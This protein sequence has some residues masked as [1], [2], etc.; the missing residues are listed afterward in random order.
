MT[1][2]S[3]TP[4]PQ[5]APRKAWIRRHP[6]WTTIIV[7]FAIGAIGSTLGGGG[8]GNPS[9]AATPASAGGYNP[10]TPP[11]GP[12]PASSAPATPAAAPAPEPSPSGTADTSCDDDLGGSSIYDPVYL[13][14][15]V[16]VTNTGNIGIIVRVR[17]AWHQEAY[18]D[19]T[20]P[21]KTV[22]VKVGRTR[23]VRFRFYVGTFAGSTSALDLWQ[24]WQDSHDG[25][26]CHARTR[27]TGTFGQ[28]Q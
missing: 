9:H 25:Q 8:N 11:A 14:G 3:S 22:R 13:T 19:V 27:I 4:P 7:L 26:P 28:P 6:V 15:E 20:V 2:N 16:D 10:P 23:P 24:S 18:P 12:T 21:A 1:T 17:M 5:P